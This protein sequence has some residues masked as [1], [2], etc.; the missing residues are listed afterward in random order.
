M[1][2]WQQFEDSEREVSAGLNDC[3]FACRALASLE[4]AAA[5][6]C[7][8]VEVPDDRRRCEDAKQRVHAAREHVRGQCTACPPGG[9]S[10]DADAPI[11]SITGP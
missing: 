7:A 1:R 4:R 9:P 8:L 11:P 6:L 3:A 2:L 10:L 5:G